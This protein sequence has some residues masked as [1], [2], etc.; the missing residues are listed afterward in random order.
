MIDFQL[1]FKGCMNKG[2]RVNN[3][4]RVVEAKGIGLVSTVAE[5]ET[6]AVWIVARPEF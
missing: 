1:T 2:C 3:C 4:I 5:L 6:M